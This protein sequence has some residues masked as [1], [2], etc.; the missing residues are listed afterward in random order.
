VSFDGSSSTDDGSITK[1]EWDFDV[2]GSTDATVATPSNAFSSTGSYD[3]VLTVTDDSGKS[4]TNTVTVDVSDTSAP[5]PSL[6][7]DTTV[8]AGTGVSFD[9]SATT[10]NVG[11]STYE[12]DFDGDGSTDATGATVGYAVDSAGTVT[13]AL[14]VTDTAGNSA[15]DTITLD[16]TS[17]TSGSAGGS[18]GGST[19]GGSPSAS[20][21]IVDASL[22]TSQLTVGD[23]VSVTVTVTNE[24]DGEGTLIAQLTTDGTALASTEVFLPAGKSTG[25][26]LSTTFEQPGDYA[27]AVSGRTVGTVTV[28]P[29]NT[30]TPIGTEMPT[31]TT[32]SATATA[33]VPAPPESRTTG[34]TPASTASPTET[35]GQPGF[36]LLVA[37]VAVL[38][39]GLIARRRER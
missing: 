31:L 34:P 15:T 36:G 17:D 29:A 33:T 20:F 5:T 23:S 30:P 38:V 35:P 22:S 12:W 2:D 6:G 19:T 25:L 32:A 3:V 24:G 13:V 21:E 10:D 28:Q 4:S 8:D 26:D 18:G 37:L 14:T 7:S 39:A 11:V 16:I 9:A 1:Y 27:L